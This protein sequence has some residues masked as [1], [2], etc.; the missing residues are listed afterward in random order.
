MSRP[1]PVFQC[2]ALKFGVGHGT[3]LDAGVHVLNGG[4]VLI[5]GACDQLIS[6]F[7]CFLNDA[8]CNNVHIWKKHHLSCRLNTKVA[9][10]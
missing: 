6:K 8:W 10:V 3:R 9:E 7:I 4:G 5:G 2:C 1:I